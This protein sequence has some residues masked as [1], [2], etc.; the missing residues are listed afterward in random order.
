[1]R[2]ILLSASLAAPG[3][4]RNSVCHSLPSLRSL[5]KGQEPKLALPGDFPV[6]LGLII[7]VAL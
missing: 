3:V 2:R 7:L 1:M 5:R 6:S 4:A